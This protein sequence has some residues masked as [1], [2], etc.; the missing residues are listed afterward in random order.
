M[1]EKD[2]VCVSNF[3]VVETKRKVLLGKLLSI[4]KEL[5]N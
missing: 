1:R 2:N 3:L 5:I 4:L